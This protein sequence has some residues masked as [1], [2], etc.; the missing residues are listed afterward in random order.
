MILNKSEFKV[1]RQECGELKGI[2]CN[3]VSTCEY[4]KEVKTGTI[5]RLSV[6]DNGVYFEVLLGVI[7]VDWCKLLLE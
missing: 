6:M 7:M 2:R 3:I 5:G 1:K 4:S